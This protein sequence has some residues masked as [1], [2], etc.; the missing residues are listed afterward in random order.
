M[1][2]IV[3]TVA[4]CDSGTATP[5]IG[6]ESTE[7]LEERQAIFSNSSRA[8]ILSRMYR[9]PFHE[10]LRIAQELDS[11]QDAESGHISDEDFQQWM[12]RVFDCSELDQDLVDDAMEVSLTQRRVHL[13]KF[14]AWYV[15]NM[16]FQIN[17]LN[18]C[19]DR[20]ASDSLVAEMA[21]RYK[22]PAF[23]IDVVKRE[24]DRYDVNRDALL[25]YSEFLEMVHTLLRAN[26]GDLSEQRIQR[27]WGEIDKYGN[28]TVNFKEFIDWFLKYFI[29]VGQHIRCCLVENF[30]E[31]FKPEVQRRNFVIQKQAARAGGA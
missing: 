9:L 2:E 1:R 22:V 20:L 30:Y 16:F 5:T 24:F 26:V 23:T 25:D 10:V 19:P 4:S 28:G 13:N 3:T 11:L 15:Q 6:N 18:S 8:G 21:Q 31:S 27:F 12:Y 7:P 29:V 14:L 17:Q